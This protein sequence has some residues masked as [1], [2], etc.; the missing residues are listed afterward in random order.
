MP[1]PRSQDKLTHDTLQSRMHRE[2]VGAPFTLQLRHVQSPSRTCVR[3]PPPARGVGPGKPGLQNTI[4]TIS[5][6]ASIQSHIAIS[7]YR[8]GAGGRQARL[9]GGG[10]EWGLVSCGRNTQ[11]PALM[12]L[13]APRREARGIGAW[14]R[15]MGQRC[16]T[17]AHIAAPGQRRISPHTYMPRP[18]TARETSCGAAY[19]RAWA[20]DT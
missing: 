15:G 10:F 14:Q 2:F 9:E 7:P 1:E 13:S 8:A 20:C 16:G 12:V 6:C 18:N 4:P 3:D 17:E 5:P 19:P 11:R